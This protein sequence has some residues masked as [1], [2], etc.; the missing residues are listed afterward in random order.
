MTWLNTPVAGCGDTVI[1]L[2]I[3]WPASHRQRIGMI[4]GLVLVFS[5]MQIGASLAQN[6]L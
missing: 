2:K 3:Y 6:V 4:M 1:T 5:I